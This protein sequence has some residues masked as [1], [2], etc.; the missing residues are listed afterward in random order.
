LFSWPLALIIWLGLDAILSFLNIKWVKFAERSLVFILALI[1][2]TYNIF[3][4]LRPS[5]CCI[6]FDDNDLFM[7]KW[8]DLNLSE[9][10]LVAIAATGSPGNFLAADGGVWL[11]HMTGV[12]VR[13]MDYQTDFLLTMSDLCEAGVRYFYV[14]GLENSF[15]E[16]GLFEA[17]AQYIIGM[18]DVKIYAAA[19]DP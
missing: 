13:K 1:G 5:D 10:D 9:F 6:F 4:P 12:P 16:Y 14:D 19:C 2:L 3:S 17:Q 11:E 8:V 18:G 7:M 15:D